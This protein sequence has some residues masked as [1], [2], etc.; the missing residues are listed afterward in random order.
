MMVVHTDEL[1]ADVIRKNA[2]LARRIEQA[3][4]AY[5]S[6]VGEWCGLD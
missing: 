1:D 6:L 3:V 5:R 4:A 2:S